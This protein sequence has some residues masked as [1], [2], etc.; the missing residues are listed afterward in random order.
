MASPSAIC[1]DFNDLSLDSVGHIHILTV[2]FTEYAGLENGEL[3]ARSSQDFDAFVTID[4]SLSFQKDLRN[5]PIAVLVLDTE[6]NTLD[7]LGKFVPLI[8]KELADLEPGKA[9]ILRL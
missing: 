4:K 3:L 1:R 5:I 8:L 2:P 6:S 9:R 7:E